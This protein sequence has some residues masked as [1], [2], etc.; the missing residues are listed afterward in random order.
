M[1]LRIRSN[2]DLASYQGPPVILKPQGDA[3]PYLASSISAYK[4]ATILNL[5]PLKDRAMHR[6]YELPCSSEDP[7]GLLEKVYGAKPTLSHDDTLRTWAKKWLQRTPPGQENFRNIH[8]L[9]QGEDIAAGFHRLVQ[10]QP[11]LQN[12]IRAAGLQHPPLLPLQPQQGWAGPFYGPTPS[13]FPVQQPL[14]PFDFEGAW[15]TQ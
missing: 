11:D 9:Q 6:M 14:P 2:L 10:A 4:L 3:L 8:I 15:S 13:P 7:V 5:E 1:E 12:D